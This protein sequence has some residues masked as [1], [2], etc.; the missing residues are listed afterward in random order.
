M[1]IQFNCPRCGSLI[2]FADKH[3]GKSA[4]CMNCEQQL[5]I[6]AKTGQPPLK[7]EP[8]VKTEPQP[9]FYH[10]VFVEN[11]KI[12]CDKDNLTAI[13]FVIAAVCLKFFSAAPAVWDLQHISPRGVIFSGSI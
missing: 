9:G 2:A 5:V 8:K 1:T 13:V 7:I 11:W 3:A 12:F 4:K 10:A 6:P